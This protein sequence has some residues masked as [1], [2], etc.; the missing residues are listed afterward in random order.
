MSN[1]RNEE[2]LHDFLVKLPKAHRWAV[3]EFFYSDID[4]AIFE[5]ESEFKLCLKETFPQLHGKRLRRVEWNMIRKL[6][7]KPRRFSTAFL[8]EERESLRSKREKIRILQ[9][10]GT[11]TADQLQ[12]LPRNIPPILP[13][14]TRVTCKVNL[15]SRDDLLATGTVEVVVNNGYKIRFDSNEP[16]LSL[17]G[18]PYFVSDLNVMSNEQLN[19]LVVEKPD[20]KSDLADTKAAMMPLINGLADLQVLLD[21]KERIVGLLHLTN[22]HAQAQFALGQ[23]L[24]MSEKKEYAQNMVRLQQVNSRL[25]KVFGIVNSSSS[26]LKTKYPT[27]IET[28]EHACANAYDLVQQQNKRYPNDPNN[29]LK[30]ESLIVHLTA[31]LEELGKSNEA[32]N[33]LI[34]DLIDSARQTTSPEL[35]TLFEQEVV[36][37][38]HHLRTALSTNILGCFSS[39]R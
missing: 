23:H 6:L 20:E 2:R 13:V 16:E 8:E 27:E 12:D 11:L 33:G 29:P 21:E 35:A 14:G 26:S 31:I 24:S 28:A 39:S 32:N 37:Q 5:S 18:E 30:S 9:R 10:N 34:Q 38:V 4:H 3:H 15:Q 22:N 36:Q 19:P 7:G 1:R 25:E 17:S